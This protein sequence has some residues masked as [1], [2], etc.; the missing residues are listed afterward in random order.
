MG[1]CVEL[2]NGQLPVQGSDELDADT[3]MAG[4]GSLDSSTHGQDSNTGGQGDNTKPRVLK[5]EVQLYKCRD[6]EYCMDV[7]VRFAHCTCNP[8]RAC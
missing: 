6:G 7:Q 8:W 1:W 5:F 4:S 3:S 2:E